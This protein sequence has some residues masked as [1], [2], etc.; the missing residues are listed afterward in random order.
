MKL[1]KETLKQ[2][3]KEEL[4]AVMNET[5]TIPSVEGNITPE[6]Q[7]K[8]TSLLATNKPEYI[9]QARMLMSALGVDPS[10]EDYILDMNAQRMMGL[11]HGHEDVTDSFPDASEMTDQQMQD[12]YNATSNQEGETFSS[13]DNEYSNTPKQKAAA[14][15]NYFAASNTR[16]SDRRK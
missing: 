4:E 9:E 2:I 1:N 3:I 6:Q 10:Y 16:R 13:I 5:M 8:I 7:G 12:F 11:A 15:R 14:K